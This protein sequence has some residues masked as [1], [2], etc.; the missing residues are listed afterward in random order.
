KDQ[1]NLD[2]I[3]D[4]VER[5]HKIT[6]LGY[7][8]LKAYVL[9]V[10]PNIPMISK[11]FIK[12]CLQV[13]SK[14]KRK[15]NPI[16]FEEYKKISE[17]YDNH[18]IRT[19]VSEK[20]SRYQIDQILT[21]TATSMKTA[22]ENNIKMHFVKRLY[23]YV[24]V[25]LNPD[26]DKEIKKKLN[27]VKSDLLNETLKS[28]L[29]YHEW[30]NKQRE[31]LKLPELDDHHHAYNIK[32]SPLLYLPCMFRMNN[33]LE[34]LEKKMFHCLPLRNSIVPKYTCID[35]KMIENLFHSAATKRSHNDNTKG[36]DGKKN[37]QAYNSA[38]W[39]TIFDA[40]VFRKAKKG[41]SFGHMIFTDG[42]GMSVL[43]KKE[44]KENKKQRGQS[45]DIN[46]I[47]EFLYMEQLSKPDLEYLKENKL[48]YIDPNKGNLIYC[49][50]DNNKTFRYTRKQRVKEQQSQKHKR[51]LERYKHKTKIIE[52]ETKLSE[53]NSKTTNYEKFMQYLKVKNEINYKLFEAYKAEFIRK[54]QF[55]TY[56]NTQR[57]EMKLVSNIKSVYGEEG[58]EI[59]LMYGDWNV[60]YQMRGIRPTPMIGL[61]RMLQKH[62]KVYNV[63]EFRTSCLDNRT[64]K[65]NENARVKDP[66]TKKTK[67]LHA[68]LVSKIPHPSLE[69]TECNSYQNRDRN[70]VL[71]IRKLVKCF[72][73]TSSRPLNYVRGTDVCP[74]NKGKSKTF[75]ASK[76]PKKRKRKDVTVTHKGV[77]TS[78][79]NDTGLRCGN[80]IKGRPAYEHLGGFSKIHSKNKLNRSFN[81]L[82]F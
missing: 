60:G 56:C 53:E 63:D 22:V 5:V 68:V 62:F 76:V 77:K 48:V 70:S 52:E 37:T 39:K 36:T 73:E 43:F 24:N 81:L 42:I 69:S 66:K 13:V 26:K 14:P 44:S 38:I 33:E 23:S 1:K 10:T 32:V 27:A 45:Q 11:E 17:F 54:A 74:E 18:F 12:A 47:D 25:M 9:H 21:Y 49:I 35:T 16:K 67:K 2:A 80:H 72:L 29:I 50:D 57:S 61:K 55:R 58:K 19:V 30:I 75:C 46:T 41:Y 65:R 34:R 59:I 6:I 40:K 71:N 78:I 15:S 20:P 28:D 64:E 7:Q 79:L 8:L 4:V 3:K 31:I 82:N 51:A